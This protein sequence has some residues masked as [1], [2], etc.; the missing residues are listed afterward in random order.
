MF[1]VWRTIKV[2]FVDC[3]PALDLGLYVLNWAILSKPKT[4]QQ[5]RNIGVEMKRGRERNKKN[6]ILPEPCHVGR[7]HHG[8]LRSTARTGTDGRD[9][10]KKKGEKK[11]MRKTSLVFPSLFIDVYTRSLDS[12]QQQKHRLL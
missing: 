12:L 3:V 9:L 7:C 1:E 10:K 8:R 2:D 6:R 11:E 4:R 5:P